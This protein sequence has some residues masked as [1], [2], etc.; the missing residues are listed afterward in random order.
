[1]VSCTQLY[2]LIPR[3]WNGTALQNEGGVIWNE[4]GVVW[5][6]AVKH[7]LTILTSMNS[8]LADTS[9]TCILSVNICT[10]REQDEKHQ[11]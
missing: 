4:D 6:E 9:K 3:P 8:S 5:N 7:T 10:Q 1:M 2:T 11:N